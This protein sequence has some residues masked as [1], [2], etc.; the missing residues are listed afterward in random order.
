MATCPDVPNTPKMIE[1]TSPNGGPSY[2]ID[3]TE[4]TNAQYMTW[5]N[6]NP[7]ITQAPECAFNMSFKPAGTLPPSNGQPITNI[8][9]CDAFAF[10][11]ANQKKLCGRIGGGPPL[12]STEI[13]VADKSQWH[14]A[15]TKSGSLT[16]PYGNTYDPMACNGQ[17]NAVGASVQVASSAK[18]EGGFPGIFDMSGNVWEWEDAC[19][20]KMGTGDMCRRRGGGFPSQQM[21]NSMDLD[22]MTSS[23][24]L[25]RGGANAST[26][27]RCCADLP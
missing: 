3:S 2:C 23:T 27:F 18:C 25:T 26:G 15:C 21:G 16:F 19:T 5:A 20:D 11:A 24:M 9:W 10:C 7:T 17:D 12:L 6:S 14:N 4:V 22:C 1:V 8:D 13:Y